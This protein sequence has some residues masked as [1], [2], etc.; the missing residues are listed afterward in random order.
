[1]LPLAKSIR[2][3]LVSEEG[4]TAVEY[5]IML[6]LSILVCFIAIDQLGDATR[7]TFRNVGANMSGS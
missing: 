6:A 1:M 2:R 5:A 4:P 3:F 7:N